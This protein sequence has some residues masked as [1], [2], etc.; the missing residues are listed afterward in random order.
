MENNYDN[1]ISL[2]LKAKDVGIKSGDY[3]DLRYL[4][5]KGNDPK[6]YARL[7]SRFERRKLVKD[8]M[9]RKIFN[10]PHQMQG[11]IILGKSPEGINR[12]HSKYAPYHMLTVGA[13]G[14]GKT[15]FLIF[16]LI[17]YLMIAN[18]IWL[19]DF[20]KREL[21]GFKRL[22]E[23]VGKEVIVCRHENLRINILDPQQLN[24]ALYINICSEFITLSLLLPPVAKLILKI[25]IT[26]LYKKCGILN[27]SKAPP[28][29]LSELI[30][31]I[32]N[33][34]GNNSAKEAIL[35]RHRALIVNQPQIF[36]VRRGF[37]ISELANKF[38]VWE[39]DGLEAQYQNLFASY[40]LSFLF[41]YRTAFPS[42]DLMIAAFDEAGR[43][44]SKKAEIA[45]EGPSYISTMT[46]VVR[47]MNIAIMALTQTC[48]DLSNSIIANSGIKA[49]F[50][51]GTVNDYD[52]F[53]K[54]IGLNSEQIQNCK[55]NLDT[56]KNIIKMGFDYMEPFQNKCSLISLPNNVT[57]TEVNQSVQELLSTVQD[58]NQVP[59]IPEK[60]SDKNTVELT[61]YEELLLEQIRNNPRITS[62][63]EHYKAANLS[64]KRGVAAKGALISKKLIREISLESG[65]RG[66]AK[67]FL[68]II[69]SKPSGR[70]GGVL[71]NFLR[72]KANSWYIANQCKTE[73]EKSIKVNN[74]VRFVDLAITWPD[75]KTEAL[76]IETEY[77]N[78]AV[79]NIQKNVEAGFE[80]ISVLTPNNKVRQAIQAKLPE[81]IKEEYAD[82]LFFS[83]ISFYQ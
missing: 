29:I 14:S 48:Y 49:L 20:I 47:G 77:S 56:G 75:G 65:K 18:G 74:Q 17:Q 37:K 46:S 4:I 5:A 82:R 30:E 25:C 34:E 83:S 6:E 61:T 80:V 70:N 52:T 19:F 57:D 2:L 43:I 45:N 35:I 64:T 26:N 39:F 79:E 71:H 55:T 21:R 60:Q 42:K 7:K 53:G 72:D 10:N 32:R 59:T 16:L 3:H 15:V 44:Y 67:A 38:I 1:I 33:F 11:D 81:N 22:A 69:P 51:V 31:E 13:T 8:L 78:R 36:N 23:K 68:E 66:A 50:R 12:Y 54:A 58:A 63:T 27:N 62:A 24:P 73:P 40:L 9:P 76:E 41:A 28:P